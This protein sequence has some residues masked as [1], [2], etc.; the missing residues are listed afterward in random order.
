MDNSTR[1]GSA[2]DGPS[3]GYER[4]LLIWHRDD[5]QGTFIPLDHELGQRIDTDFGETAVDF[6]DGRRKVNVLILV[7]LERSVSDRVSDSRGFP[8]MKT[9]D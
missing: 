7:I 4:R 6:F 3:R 5:Q 1:G 2:R 8:K 9:S